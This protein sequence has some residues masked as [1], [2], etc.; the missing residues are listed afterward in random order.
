MVLRLLVERGGEYHRLR[1]ALH[2]RHFLWTLVDEQHDED[3]IW[4]VLRD[5]IRHL[6]KEDR[7]ADARR[8]NDKA[9]LTE[10]NRREEVH[11]AHRRLARRRLEDDAARGERGREVF[12]V[13]D[14]RGLAG[15]LAVHRHDVA[16]RKKTILVARVADRA[17]HGVA[18]AERMAADLLLRDEHVLG[19]GEEVRLRAAEEAVSFLHDFKAARGHH[20][21]AAVEVAADRAEDDF[22]ALHRAKVL[23][24]RVRPHLRDDFA[25]VP[26]MDVLEIVLGQVGVARHGGNWRRKILRHLI[27]RAAVALR[28]HL[29][30]LAAVFEVRTIPVALRGARQP[31]HPPTLAVAHR[32]LARWRDGRLRRN[33]C[34]GRCGRPRL[35]RSRILL[36][37]ACCPMCRHALLLLYACC[38]M[39]RRALLLLYACCPMCRRALLLLY[40][41]CLLNGH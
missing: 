4:V 18:R 40:A 25:V 39:C 29:D 26:G 37:Y 33:V 23:G 10:A 14:T 17:H 21:A 1:V 31:F 28:R 9:A 32:L 20:G 16:E 13:D 35:N 15:R 11:H 22:V 30:M 12:E 3:G 38:P 2:V 41:C 24:V 36:L 34:N 27:G 8:R 7:L 19:T 5:G 6:L